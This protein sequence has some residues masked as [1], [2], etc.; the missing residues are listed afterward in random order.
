M[1]FAVAMTALSRA[2]DSAGPSQF[3]IVSEFFSDYGPSFYYRVLDVRQDGPDS[4]V[5]YVRIA[6]MNIYCPGQIVQAV[7]ARVPNKSPAQLAGGNNPCAIKPSSLRSAVKRYSRNVGTF[8]TIRFGI[9]ALCPTSPLTLELPISETLDLKA[10]KEASPK[11]ARLWNLSSI[12]RG[13]VFGEKDPFH[14]R[15]EEEDAILQLTGQTL[16][17]ELLAG[18]YNAGLKAASGIASFTKL[19]QSYRGPV[20]ATEA[21]ATFVPVLENPQQLK[22]SKYTAPIYPPLA[23]LARIQGKVELQ[24]LV[25]PATGNVK[26]IAVL[27]GHKLLAPSAIAAAQQ[28]LFAPDFKLPEQVAVTLNYDLNCPAN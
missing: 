19:L 27:S 26:K 5:R 21:N 15:T 6:P 20:S 17:L 7:E 22:F 2:A 23:K 10:M 28:W 9:V 8:E 4:L 18:R 13:S 11:F 16:V 3:Y 1:F 24:L 14:D 12:I 25:E